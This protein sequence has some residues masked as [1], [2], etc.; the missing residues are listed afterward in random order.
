MEFTAKE[1]AAYLK[2]DIEGDPN[3]KV[4]G[5]A[6]IEAGKPGT[7]C[8]FANAKYEHF[9]YGNKADIMIINRDY[10]LQQPLGMTVIRVDNAYSAIASLLEYVSEKKRKYRRHRGWFV[11]RF[12]STRIGKRVSM[13][14]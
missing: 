12:F 10:K 11:R 4:T 9:L 1:I 14:R 13:W 5:F 7:L 3:V 6:R 2:G 8:F